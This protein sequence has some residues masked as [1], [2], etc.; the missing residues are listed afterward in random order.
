MKT[1][2]EMMEYLEKSGFK[3]HFFSRHALKKRAEMI[4]DL[5]SDTEEVKTCF[6]A[7]KIENDTKFPNI[8]YGPLTFAYMNVCFVALTDRR[9]VEAKIDNLIIPEKK[10]ITIELT[11]LNDITKR[12]KWFTK[13]IIDTIKEQL[14]YI[15]FNKYGNIAYSNFQ[16]AYAKLKEDKEKQEENKE[17]EEKVEEK[18]ENNLNSYDGAFNKLSEKDPKLAITQ[19]KELLEEGLITKKQYDDKINS[20]LNKM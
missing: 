12:K 19:M 14:N 17:K 8:I 11:Y 2:D 20:I 7:K 16:K 6:V 10:I 9:I 3:M 15:M 1:A 13:I 5:I 18:N 4:E